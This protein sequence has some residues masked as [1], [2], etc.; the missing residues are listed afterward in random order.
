MTSPGA[1]AA[2]RIRAL[3]AAWARAAARRD[4]DG[5]MAIY[6][7]DAEELLP[8]SPPLVGL[9]AIRRF[10]GEL[11]ERFPRSSHEFEPVTITVALSGDLAVARGWYRFTADTL[12]PEQSQRGKFVSVWARREGDWRLLINISNGDDP[13]P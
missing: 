8:G 9:Q 13:S 3:D 5:M 4:L 11:L 6:A 12:H 1:D 10:Y 7:P 2:S